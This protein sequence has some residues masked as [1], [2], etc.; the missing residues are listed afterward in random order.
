MS[1][2]FCYE[3]ASM[4]LLI[5]VCILVVSMPTASAVNWSVNQSLRIAATDVIMRAAPWR[6]ATVIQT[7]QE[8]D[9]VLFLGDYT[10]EPITV[11]LRGESVT[12]PFIRVRSDD[13]QEGW[14]FAGLV[15]DDDEADLLAGKLPLIQPGDHVDEVVRLYGRQAVVHDRRMRNPASNEILDRVSADLAWEYF[16]F[17]SGQGVVFGLSDQRVTAVRVRQDESTDAGVRSFWRT[18]EGFLSSPLQPEC[19]FESNASDCQD[20]LR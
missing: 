7:L 6:G 17:R 18:V 8:Y 19:H 14:V 11:T 10:V 13:G 9:H 12:A 15:T 1:E 5:I 16:Y 4:R 20:Y 2:R 3:F